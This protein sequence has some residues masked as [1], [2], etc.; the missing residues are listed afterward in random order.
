MKKQAFFNIAPFAD[1]IITTAFRIKQ[2]RE[3]NKQVSTISQNLAN[4]QISTQEEYTKEKTAG[5]VDTVQSY[6]NKALEHTADQ[7]VYIIRHPESLVTPRNIAYT[8]AGITASVAAPAWASGP[9]E[10]EPKISPKRIAKDIILANLLGRSIPNPIVKSKQLAIALKNKQ[11]F[12][13]VL[14]ASALLPTATVAYEVGRKKIKNEDI[15]GKDILK[16]YV[17]GR[18]LQKSIVLPTL[19]LKYGVPY[20]AKRIAEAKAGGQ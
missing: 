5:F 19:G 4:K 12:D 8:A 1:D 10:G 6:A 3:K 2:M 7:I 20:I 9:K 14:Y 16:S 13:S 18:A 15:H 17:K 11:K